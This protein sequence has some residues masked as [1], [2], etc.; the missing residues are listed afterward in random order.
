LERLI[1]KDCIYFLADQS[2]ASL[3][4]QGLSKEIARIL[5]GFSE[6]QYLSW[7]RLFTALSAR[8]SEKI[9]LILD[10]FPYLVQVSPEMPS[11]LQKMIDKKSR[12]N[13]IIC[14]S[15]QRM[16][17]GLVLDAA[18]PLYGRADEIIKLQP[19][20]PGWI[21][22]AFPISDIQSIEAFA[23]WGGI[24]RYWALAKRYASTSQAVMELMYDKNGVLHE[25]PLRLLSDDMKSTVQSNSLL[26]LIAQGAHKIS[27]IAARIQIPA[28][29]LNRPL[30]NLIDLGYLRRE[31]P[32]GE[33]LKSTKRTLYKI[34]D[35]FLLYWYTFIHPNKSLLERDLVKDV[36]SGYEDRFTI[37][38]AEVWESLARESTCRIPVAG[39]SWKPAQRWWG[40]GI[41]RKIL[42]IDVVAESFDGKYLLIGE[43][44]WNE[45]VDLQEISNSLNRR[46]RNF[47]HA[48]GRKIVTAVWLKHAAGTTPV[49]DAVITPRE[50]LDAMV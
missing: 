22:K 7:D 11:I 21:R 19:L 29:S 5:P 4:I 20:A 38:I 42:E 12:I 9:T 32:F 15:S 45:S 14:G 6:A 36:Y 2:N 23:A 8:V 44:K 26:S 16:M 50:V 13:L 27:E 1:G 18:A 49:V 37:H 34:N 24:P 3:Q 48:Q 39:I 25:E 17:H 33:N 10:E 40:A 30:T 28:T 47:P 43:V 35:P 41:D 31:L 46:I